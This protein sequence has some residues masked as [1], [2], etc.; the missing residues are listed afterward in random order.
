ML[1]STLVY[2][3]GF[4]GLV[5]G[6]VAIA[7]AFRGGGWASGIFGALNILLGLALIGNPV[8]G[9]LGASWMYG[10]LAIAGGLATIFCAFS[11]RGQ[12]AA[13]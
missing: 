4:T 9:A 12:A 1:P 5:T 11:S 2:F 13:A 8:L 7:D 3:L 10:I 6:V